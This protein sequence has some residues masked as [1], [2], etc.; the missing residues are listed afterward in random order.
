MIPPDDAA[1][2]V[3]EGYR[4]E[5]VGQ[6]LAPPRSIVFVPAERLARIARAR[7]VPVR[8]C[9]E[10]LDARHLALTPMD[11]APQPGLSAPPEP[12]FRVRG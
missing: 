9:G 10:L 3:A 6:A 12:L 8:L 7:A 1:A 2:L 5:P 4:L 11:P